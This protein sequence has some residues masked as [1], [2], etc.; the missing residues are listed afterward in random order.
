VGIHHHT[1]ADL[2]ISVARIPIPSAHA[3]VGVPGQPV[4]VG[5]LHLLAPSIRERSP[6]TLHPA[7]LGLVQNH[8]FNIRKVRN[9]F[10]RGLLNFA[11]YFVTKVHEI[12]KK[13]YEIY[14]IFKTDRKMSFLGL[15]W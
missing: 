2:K 12:G 11:S 9:L 6:A 4:R 3:Q 10:T 1:A 14:V 7:Q 5:P 8:F 15:L 13:L